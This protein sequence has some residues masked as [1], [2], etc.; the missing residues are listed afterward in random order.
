MIP[1]KTEKWS[2]IILFCELVHNSTS[3]IEEKKS[4][5]AVDE[6]IK[7]SHWNEPQFSNIRNLFSNFIN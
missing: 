1:N 5:H 4:C 7:S 2:F 6:N 3:G